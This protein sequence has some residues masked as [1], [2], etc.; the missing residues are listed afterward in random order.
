ME[1]VQEKADLDELQKTVKSW[2]RKVEIAEVN[3]LLFGL[4]QESGYPQIS[5]LFSIFPADPLN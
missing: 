4:F 3:L 1:Y 2:E 5:Y